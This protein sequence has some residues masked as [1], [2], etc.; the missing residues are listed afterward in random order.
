[1]AKRQIL[2]IE[3]DSSIRQ[4]MVDALGITGYGVFQADDGISGLE[5][6]LT[7]ACDLVL[8]DLVLPGRD[9]LDILK[10]VRSA[11]PTLPVIVLTARGE[12]S[13]R[14]RGLRLGADDYVIK[15]FS[16]RELL[17]RV[18]AVLRRSPERPTDVGELTVPGGKANFARREVRFRDGQR[19]ELSEREAELLRYLACNAGRAI[20][21]EEVLRC[22]WGLGAGGAETRTVDMTVVRLRQK[23]RDDP[24]N[25]RLLLTV[26]GK[27]YMLEEANRPTGQQATVK[28]RNPE[29]GTRN[30]GR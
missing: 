2:I 28:R 9:G 22:V 3:D 23:L 18:E 30:P 6:A 8:L 13:D 26:R 10:E 14:V 4:A 20:S 5:M 1:M 7:C 29:Q 17:A 19:C 24:A 11:R 27:G 12:E 16:V 15:P 21:R 25:P